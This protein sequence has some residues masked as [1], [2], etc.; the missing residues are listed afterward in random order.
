MK[1]SRF[2]CYNN[3]FIYF[4]ERNDVYRGDSIY[5]VPKEIESTFLYNYS[6]VFEL[7]EQLE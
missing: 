3:C 6:R 1:I 4:E 5:I 7:L 2:Y